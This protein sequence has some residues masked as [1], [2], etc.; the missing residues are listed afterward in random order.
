MK[1]TLLKCTNRAHHTSV[2]HK[3][4]NL[5]Q[6]VL[7]TFEIT[8]NDKATDS[9]LFTHYLQQINK[10]YILCRGHICASV[11]PLVSRTATLN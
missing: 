6:Q 11:R 8:D 5:L 4:I 10:I 7:P 2:P 1:P 9:N 3:F